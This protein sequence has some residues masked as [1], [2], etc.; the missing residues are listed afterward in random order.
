MYIQQTYIWKCHTH[1]PWANTM[2]LWVH[3]A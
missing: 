2:R 1:C 3:L